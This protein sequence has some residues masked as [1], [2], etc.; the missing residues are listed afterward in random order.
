MYIGT[1]AHGVLGNPSS[2]RC[3][4]SG[5]C[6]DF[7]ILG[8]NNEDVEI[9]IDCRLFSVFPVRDVKVHSLDIQ[10]PPLVWCFFS[11][12]LGVQRPSQEV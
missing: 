11:Y 9:R 4:L 2:K 1:T 5:N 8:V 12:V 6:L 10:T 3:L 7:H